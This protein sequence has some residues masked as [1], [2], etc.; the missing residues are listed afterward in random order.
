[1]LTTSVY[2]GDENVDTS[3]NERRLKK[4]EDKKLELTGLRQKYDHLINIDA[5]DPA[6]DPNI[7]RLTTHPANRGRPNRSNDLAELRNG[8]GDEPLPENV[9][10]ISKPGIETNGYKK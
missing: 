9:I 1:M 4:L 6:D 2:A 7:I 10:P 3:F 8:I 5:D